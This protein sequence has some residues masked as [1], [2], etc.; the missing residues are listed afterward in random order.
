MSDVIAGIIGG[1]VGGTLGVIGTTVSSYFGPRKLEERREQRRHEREDGPRKEMLQEL[2]AD[3]KFNDG[4]KLETLARVT[5]STDQQ[6]RRLLI[7]IGA[8]GILLKKEDG[9]GTD[10]GWVL[11]SRKPVTER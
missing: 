4:R 10:E 3:S 8:R 1:T 5:G 2:L 11:R 7:E 6:C 9:T